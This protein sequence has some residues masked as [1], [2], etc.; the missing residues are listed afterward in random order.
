VY[1]GQIGLWPKPTTSNLVITINAKIKAVDL[2][3][4]DYSTGNVVS[5]AN[6]GT[7]MVGTGTSWTGN[8]VGRFL[9]VT[10]GNAANTGDGVWYEIGAVADGTD[11]TLLRAYGGLAISAATAPYAI[12]QMSYLPDEFHDTPVYKAAATYWFKEADMARAEAFQGK[13]QADI[14]TYQKMKTSPVSDL[15]VDDGMPRNI[16]NPNLTVQL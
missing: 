4:A 11:L 7:A 10:L 3:V 13:Y 1:N 8:M 16:I 12:G 14:D 6:G 9:S 5:I 2:S 15:V